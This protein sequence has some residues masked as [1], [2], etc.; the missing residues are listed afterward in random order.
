MAFQLPEGERIADGV[1]LIAREQIDHAIDE[2]SDRSLALDLAVHEVRKRCKKL[3]GLLRLIRP[4]LG[5]SYARE[6]AHFRAAARFL[7]PLRDDQTIIDA[8]HALLDHFAEQTDRKAFGTIQ[9][10]LT[11]RRKQRAGRVTD[12]EE[13]IAQVRCQMEAGRKRVAHWSIEIAGAEAWR[14]GFEQTYR[15]AREAMALA[16]ETLTTEHF[17]EWR[18]QVK[19]HWHH[20]RILQPLWPEVL[21]VRGD[22]ANALGETL[23]MH[24]DL[25]VLRATLLDEREG[26]GQP[27]VPALVVLIDRRRTELAASAR[28]LGA[29]LFA[30]KAARIG[31][32][33]VRYW[34]TWQDEQVARQ[35]PESQPAAISA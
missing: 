17:H 27:A 8:F 12:V 15:R 26:F 28:P 31:Q 9:R 33:W 19:Y 13:R 5:D 7:S 1:R 21:G 22:A 29:R 11:R 24:H 30:D 18:K 14:G 10:R 35:A 25:A 34:D 6:N 3:R 23:G 20:T 4:C 2:L 16:Y 32:R